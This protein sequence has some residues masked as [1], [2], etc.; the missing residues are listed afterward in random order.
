MTDKNAESWNQFEVSG[1]SKR[2]RHLSAGSE[3]MSQGTMPNMTMCH[4]LLVWFG[5]MDGAHFSWPSYW[6]AEKGPDGRNGNGRIYPCYVSIPGRWTYAAFTKAGPERSLDIKGRYFHRHAEKMPILR[7]EDK[8]AAL[9]CLLRRTYPL[10]IA[11]TSSIISV[12]LIS[13]VIRPRPC[14]KYCG[15]LSQEPR[16]LSDETA[17]YVD[18]QCKK[19]HFSKDYFKDATVDLGEVGRYTSQCQEELKLHSGMGNFMSWRLGNKSEELDFVFG[20]SMLL[21]TLIV[22]RNWPNCNSGLICE[23]TIQIVHLF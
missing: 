23:W 12:E 22:R 8:S 16:L 5:E 21:R 3:T 2:W 14:R 18:Q 15:W 7:Q 20:F 4:G 9:S 10:R 13:L 17:G 11:S 6:Q 19:N 1:F